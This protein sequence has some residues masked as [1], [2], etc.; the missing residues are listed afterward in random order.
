MKKTRGLKLSDKLTLA[1]TLLLL[2]VSAVLIGVL[3]AQFREAQHQAIRQRLR[4][5]VSLA[6]PAIDGKTHALIRTAQDEN[7]A[8]YQAILASLTAIQQKSDIIK[9]VYTLRQQ[10]DGALVFVVDADP[11]VIERAHTGEV[12]ES[13]SPLLQQGLSLIDKAVVEENPNTDKWGTFLSGYAP[14]Y[15][16]NGTQDSVVGIDIDLSTL[17]AYEE[18]A[19]QAAAVAFLVAVPLA[20]S[21]GWWLARSMTLPIQDILGGAEQVAMGRFDQRV[22]VRSQDEL[23]ALAEAF[24]DMMAGL[25]RSTA[26][27]EEHASTLSYQV[28]QRTKET[29][30]RAMQ[31]AAGAQVARV[32]TTLLDPDEL[33]VK[34]VELIQK[35]FNYYY[36]ALFLLD[37]EKHY[38]VLQHGLGVGTAHEAG[39]IM[40]ERGHKLEIGGHSMIGWTCAN[41]QARIA[42]DV[43]KDAV[44]FA[45]PLL[46][47][48]HSEMAL[49]LRVGDRVVGA[50]SVQSTKTAAFDQNDIAAL[51]GMADQIAVALENANLFRQTQKTLQE[52]DEANRLLVSRGW[53]NY[54]EKA[55]EVRHAE[56]RPEGVRVA[57]GALPHLLDIPLRVGQQSIGTLI[58]ERETER[59]WT[60]D[61][62]QAIQAIIQQAILAVDNARL[63]EEA[64]RLAARERL[65]GEVTTRIRSATTMEGVLNAAVREIGAT[66]G[67]T[68][69]AIELAIEQ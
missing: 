42:L 8:A 18:Q 56:F 17:T 29:E 12:Y 39:R 62:T 14:I 46:P 47:D 23:G 24:N 31:I 3:Y 43:G 66:T 45:N 34:V 4:D 1:N 2:L 54:L 48:T 36:V 5:I 19:L 44:R 50:L 33:I 55:L 35:Q 28:E 60:K 65:I 25:N 53:Q 27:L 40:Q 49:P 64:Q 69:A 15:D 11:N 67:A 61:E 59:P 7:S 21:F 10:Q 58:M 41:K 68:Y 38:A 57:S 26:Q 63:F 30:K 13:P 37:A 22:P 32:A 52:L 9:Y 51:Q 16:E 6:A 20:V